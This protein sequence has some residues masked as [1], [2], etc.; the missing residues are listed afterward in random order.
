MRDFLGLGK[1]ANPAEGECGTH[2][3]P[4]CSLLG[5]LSSSIMDTTGAKYPM[6]NRAIEHS[7]SARKKLDDR[8]LEGSA[9][10][11]RLSY[12]KQWPGMVSNRAR[13][14]ANAK[15]SSMQLTI[16][17]GGHVNVYSNISVDRAEAIM[18]L[19]AKGDSLP[20]NVSTPPFG[21][22]HTMV[23]PGFCQATT[24]AENGCFNA[25]MGAPIHF[26]ADQASQNGPPPDNKAFDCATPNT[27]STG[28]SLQPVV[29]RAL[30]LAR[31]ASLARFLEERK[32]R[33]QMMSPYYKKQMAP[34]QREQ[35][36]GLLQNAALSELYGQYFTRPTMVY[37]MQ[38][39]NNMSSNDFV[40][41]E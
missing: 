4:N 12:T 19:A 37:H 7:L 32:E 30:P 6:V 21:V 5:F 41:K 23:A 35:I 15:P 10:T 38:E 14:E 17:Y 1:L 3:E 24:A 22:T 34:A 27:P 39:Q 11:V 13:I 8:Y 33:M 20:P 16:F 36:V 25:Q 40:A 2:E 18:H 9:E 31:K 29:P 28:T 26:S